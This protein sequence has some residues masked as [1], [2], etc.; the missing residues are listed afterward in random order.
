MNIIKFRYI[1]YCVSLALVVIGV[2]GLFSY[3]L[4]FS[5]D[6]KGG[7][8][9]LLTT[10]S[11]TDEVKSSIEEFGEVVVD[12]GVNN[13]LNVYFSESLQTEEVENL[14][15]KVLDLDENAQFDE[16]RVVEPSVSNELVYKTLIAITFS[17]LIIFFYI[18][19]SFKGVINSVSALIAMVHDMFILIG[20]FSIFGHFFGAEVD[21][22]IVT[23]V[24]TVLSFSLYD[25]IVIFDKLRDNQKKA[26]RQNLSALID[27]SIKQTMVRS[28]NN[29]LTS[30]LALFAL[31]LFVSGPIFWF[32]IALLVGVVL[33]TYSS[34][35]IAL[36]TYYDIKRILKKN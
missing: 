32:S 19:Y 30:I 33:G 12:A 28:V 9:I 11:S 27:L 31:S 1:F 34:P 10:S 2:V 14:K 16:I 23:A 29:S 8:S 20:L 3:K 36:T 26:K 24:L 7:T 35:F 21:L 13:T 5:A 4:N 6:F 18:A 25:T 15:S 22:L 17:L